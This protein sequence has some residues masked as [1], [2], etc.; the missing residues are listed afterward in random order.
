M[1]RMGAGKLLVYGVGVSSDL[2]AELGAGALKFI[3]LALRR[4]WFVVANVL[5]ILVIGQHGFVTLIVVAIALVALMTY[6]VRRYKR[7]MVR[8]ALPAKVRRNKRKNVMHGGGL[9]ARS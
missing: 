2:L 5:G 3:P 4:A 1:R 8:R 6:A 9:R 7:R